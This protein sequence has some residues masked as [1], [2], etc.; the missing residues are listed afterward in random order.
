MPVDGAARAAAP[1]TPDDWARVRTLAEDALALPQA[2]R[3]AFL[4]PRCR[5]DPALRARV[6]R[7]V[8][9]CER[10]DARGDFLA[11]P[12]GELAAPLVADM[13]RVE[14]AP[15]MPPARQAREDGMCLRLGA[16][17]SERYRI[18]REIGVGGAAT[19]YRAHDVRHGRQVAIKVLHPEVAAA[20]G[21]E[22]FLAEIRTMAALQ[23][24]HILPLF[25]SG[26]ANGLLFYVMPLVEDSLRAQ[27]LR[28]GRLAVADA[29]RIARDVAGAID[30]AHR[31][32]VIHRDIKPENILLHEGRPVVA[33][34]GIALAAPDVAGAG[35]HRITQPGLS[36]GTPRYMSPEQT[37]GE[38]QLTAR[39]DVHALGVL[40]FEM[41]TGLAPFTGAT[42][43]EVVRRVRSERP[44]A[45]GWRRGDIPLWVEGAVLTALEKAPADRYATAAEFARALDETGHQRTPHAS[46]GEAAAPA[47]PAG[48][49]E[50]RVLVRTLAGLVAVLAG[51]AAWGWSRAADVPA[52]AVGAGDAATVA[53][54]RVVRLTVST[55]VGH[56]IAPAAST[57][58]LAV[59]PDGRVV[60]YVAR[61]SSGVPRLHARALDAHDSY[62]VAGTERASA[63]LFSPDG[64][65]IA[66]WARDRLWK[67]AASGGEPQQLAAFPG[68]RGAA[69]ASR[70]V[71]V[72]A[73]AHG[74]YTLAAAGG[75]PTLLAATE[76][77]DVAWSDPV[78]LPGGDG[79]VF[80]IQRGSERTIGMASLSAR[81]TA[82][83]H[84]AGSA[85]LG[86]IAGHLVY[87]TSDEV[88]MAVP[89]DERAMRVTGDAVPVATDVRVSAT[90]T[91]HAA[92]SPSGT[93]A[94][95][96]GARLTSADPGILVV[97]DWAAEVRASLRGRTAPR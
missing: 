39:S 48:R 2:A 55:P 41:L 19:V 44:P 80:A 30:Y 33:D 82:N 64:R 87:A 88:L 12:A 59:S 89:L 54:A 79:V 70:D 65:W 21:A 63:P 68:S 53:P 16:A 10:V 90:G 27:L 57:R 13:A 97:H 47:A 37:R 67:V 18:E 85:P 14:L 42:T 61:D 46:G 77:S 24:P 4:E 25:D 62:V 29:L 11:R 45:I 76:S 32:G 92:L 71:I 84:V 69:W 1:L 23:H 52:A 6:D 72:L 50:S 43:E 17:L 78:A 81:S 5:D 73:N 60:V 9:A 58:D 20:L 36:L 96:R 91:A 51:L 94:Y 86:V 31:H 74:L 7:L 75:A 93:L 3:P 83:L 40:T 95:R 56:T 8:A 15:P 66:F 35:T 49:R 28:E 26:S 22:R 34:F 38:R